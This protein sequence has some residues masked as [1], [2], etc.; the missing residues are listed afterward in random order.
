MA[1][2]KI[3]TELTDKEVLNILVKHFELEL[4]GAE[5]KVSNPGRDDTYIKYTITTKLDKLSK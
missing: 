4:D 3:I 1:V 2:S 5:M